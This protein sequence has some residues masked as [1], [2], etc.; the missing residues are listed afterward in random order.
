MV[1]IE[2]ICPHSPQIDAN[3]EKANNYVGTLNM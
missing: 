3:E 2:Y 1:E